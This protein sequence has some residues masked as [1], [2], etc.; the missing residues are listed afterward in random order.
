MQ[1][2]IK[3]RL[4]LTS[5]LPRQADFVTMK[6]LEVLRKEIEFSEAEISEYGLTVTDTTVEWNPEKAGATK[7]VQVGE[8]AEKEI[9]D[10]L[11]KLNEEKKLTAD[12]LSLYEKFVDK[13]TPGEPSEVTTAEAEPV[14]ESASESVQ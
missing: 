10:T 5:V 6:K 8:I 4:T 3:E 2:T 1:L 11:K 13:K 9:V 7:E 12:H 14:A